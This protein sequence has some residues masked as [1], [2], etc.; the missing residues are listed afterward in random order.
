MSVITP[1]FNQAR[2]IRETIESIRMQDYPHVEHIVAD[3]GSTD[4]TLSILQQYS[5]FGDRFRFVSEPDRGQSHALNKALAL[6]RGEI[7]GWLNSDDT[8]QPGAIRKA[9]QAL[10]ARPECGMANGKCYVINEH[11]QV[12]S[13]IHATPANYTSLYHS[14]VV[15]QPAAFVRKNAL[16]QVGGFDESLQFCMDY[17][18]WIR[19]S[20]SYPIAH[21]DDFLANARVYSTTK[22]A[23]LWNTVGISEVLMTVEKHYGS[24]S[25]SWLRHAP[26]YR[27]KPVQRPAVP[28]VESPVPSTFGHPDR[29]TSSNRYGDSFAPPVFRMTVQTDPTLTALL[30]KGRALAHPPGQP[31]PFSCNALVNGVSVGSFPV[32]APSF[33]WEIPL[34]AGKPINQ[35]DILAAKF[36]RDPN[37]PNRLISYIADEVLPLTAQEAA[38]FKRSQSFFRR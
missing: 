30:V 23:T 29:I 17:D 26:H 19:I 15:C 2:F 21:I 3:G 31:G 27:K 13:A 34:D 7:I 10:Q 38:F 14:C 32:S 9:V 12:Q 33:L 8:Y 5:Q 22:T 11:S 18:L 6:A 16:L 35:I 37:N 28:I 4:G 24:V 36:I 25:P 1:S 20:K